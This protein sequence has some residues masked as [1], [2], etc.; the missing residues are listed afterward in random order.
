[1]GEREEGGEKK[2]REGEGG[3]MEEDMDAAGILRGSTRDPTG[4]AAKALCVCERG[5]KREWVCVNV[6]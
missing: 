4:Y 5:I 1:M 3:W 6:S 2:R